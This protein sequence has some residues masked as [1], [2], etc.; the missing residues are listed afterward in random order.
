MSG[1]PKRQVNVEVFLMFFGVATC[2]VGQWATA[3]VRGEDHALDQDEPS[4]DRCTEKMFL[5]TRN[6]NRHNASGEEEPNCRVQNLYA[7]QNAGLF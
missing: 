6:G 2:Q 7:N 1:Q 5:D 4:Q 3:S